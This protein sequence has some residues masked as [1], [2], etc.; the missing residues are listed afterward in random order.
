MTM[1][2]QQQ[3]VLDGLAGRAGILDVDARHNRLYSAGDL[4]GWVATFRH[5]GATY[6]RAGQTFTDLSAAFDGGNGQRLV[7]VDHEMSVDGVEATQR[8]VALLFVGAELRATGIYTDSL[9]YERGGWYFTS[10][11]LNWDLL[12]SEDALPV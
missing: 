4:A 2:Y 11:E 3:H 9:I 10:R 5:S 12:P 1:T 7:T 8:C 6:V